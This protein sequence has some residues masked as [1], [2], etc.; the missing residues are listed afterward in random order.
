MSFERE[1]L[2]DIRARA[3]DHAKTTG[4]NPDWR[5]TYEALASAADHL[6]AM[7]ARTEDVVDDE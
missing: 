3:N 2:W 5:R 6:D 7:I 1:E 4:L